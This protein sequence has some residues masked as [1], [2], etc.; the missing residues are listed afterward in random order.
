MKDNT[1]TCTCFVVVVGCCCCVFVCVVVVFWGGGVDG[2]GGGAPDCQSCNNSSE[3]VPSTSSELVDNR[4]PTQE[5]KP[6]RSLT[7]SEKG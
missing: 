5:S 4:L 6:A 7:V 3:P 2:G 1:E